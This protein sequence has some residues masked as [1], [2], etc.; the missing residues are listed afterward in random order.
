MRA[1]VIAMSVLGGLLAVGVGGPPVL[2]ADPGAEAR[3]A[4]QKNK[5]P[6]YDAS[7]DGYRPM[8][9]TKVE[10]ATSADKDFK[11]PN[12]S[13]P[14]GQIILWMGLGIFL[15]LLMVAIAKVLKIAEPPPVPEQ[16]QI[17]TVSVEQLEALPESAR[18]VRD[19]LGEA[20]RLAAQAAYGPAMTFYHSWQLVQLDKQGLLELQKGKTNRRYISEVSQ[21][22][23]MLIELFR[24]STRLFEDAFFG[25]L[26]VT[27]EQFERVWNERDSF[28]VSARR[29]GS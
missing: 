4:L 8:R 28:A 10:P 25:H 6:W 9:P 16:R 7:R 18:D 12:A 27:Q 1:T 15:A 19:L 17:T 20:A 21:S 29:A 11:L 22:S 23:P 5:Y 14:F 2:A 13:I 26:P 24:N 3:A